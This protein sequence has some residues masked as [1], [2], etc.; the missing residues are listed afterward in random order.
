[1]DANENMTT[2]DFYAMLTGNGL[3]MR[4]ASRTRHPD[5]RWATTATFKSGDRIGRHPI[6]GCF[7]TQIFHG[8]CNMAGLYALS[9]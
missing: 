5:H 7:V 3:F 9:W 6:D 2:G 8:G 1:M 4:E